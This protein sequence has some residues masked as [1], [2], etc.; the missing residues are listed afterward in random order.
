MFSLCFIFPLGTIITGFQS[1]SL[2]DICRH[3][4]SLPIHGEASAKAALYR[5]RLFLLFQ[6][7]SRDQHFIKPAFDADVET[8]PSCQVRFP[9]VF[10]YVYTYE[11]RFCSISTIQFMVGQLSTIQSL[12]GQRGRRWVMG[13]ISQLEDG[14]F[15]L[16]DLTAAVEIDFSKAI[17]FDLIAYCIWP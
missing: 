1:Q 13:V 7:V 10:L 3:A 12:V 14:H 2:F 9:S 11:M 5:D 4:G 16:E 17:S 8:S 6:R 15:Y